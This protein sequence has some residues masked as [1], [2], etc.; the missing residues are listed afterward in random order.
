M[1]G[2]RKEGRNLILTSHHI[3]ELLKINC[4]T[5]QLLEDDVD[6]LCNLGVG[7][8]FLGRTQKSRSIK[9]LGFETRQLR[10]DVSA[11]GVTQW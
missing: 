8:Y 2:G 7:K 11:A 3:T 9:R 6:N 4:T 5:I 10:A 1:R